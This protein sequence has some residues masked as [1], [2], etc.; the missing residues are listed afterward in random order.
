MHHD[1]ENL[2][3]F[4]H[5]IACKQTECIMCSSIHME[6][7]V[8]ATNDAL[9]RMNESCKTGNRAASRMH[10]NSRQYLAIT[11]LYE[12]WNDC[13]S[14]PAVRLAWLQKTHEPNNATLDL[15]V[16]MSLAF[17]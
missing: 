2:N 9:R 17:S 11:F 4:S 1:V 13:A 5:C 3:A 15:L 8:T 14:D 16:L 7:D 10:R 12:R 6:D